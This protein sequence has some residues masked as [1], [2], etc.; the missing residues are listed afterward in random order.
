MNDKVRDILAELKDHAPFTMFGAV[1]GIVVMLLFKNLSESVEHSLFYVFHP[2][3]VVLGAIV[4]TA[5]F[6][7]H[8]K[9]QKAAVIILVSLIGSLGTCTVSD[10]IIPYI[11]E[12]L[13]G[14]RIDIHGHSQSFAHEAH[15]GFIEGWFVVLPAAVL[16]MLIGY[17]K[18]NT[19]FPHAGHILVSTWAS[20]FHML[21]AMGSEVSAIKIVGGF[22]FLFLAVWL[23]CCFSDL[24][25]P[26]LFIKTDGPCKCVYH[27]HGTE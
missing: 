20:A 22:V 10:S 19:K 3:H 23:P 18:P 4:T 2:I 25:L 17:F 13:L 8:A 6:R 15:I 9:H 24:I 21:M 26:M 11:G 7:L 5:M 1:T 14:M 27:G 12:Q 16:G